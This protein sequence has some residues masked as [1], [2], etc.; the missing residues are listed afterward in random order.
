MDFKLSLCPERIFNG[1]NTTSM[2]QENLAIIHP[3]KKNKK[4]YY[5]A[6]LLQPPD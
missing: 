2:S 3:S 4:F 6:T 5:I 1:D